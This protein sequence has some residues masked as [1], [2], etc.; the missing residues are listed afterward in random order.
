[1]QQAYYSAFRNQQEK[2]S[3]QIRSEIPSRENRKQ[4]RFFDKTVYA[5]RRRIENMFQKIKD[6]R[7]IAMRVDKLDTSFM[8][9]IALAL[10]KLEVC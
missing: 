2:D 6:N 9:F 7:R 5:W 10:L 8:G 3:H 1:M 4:K